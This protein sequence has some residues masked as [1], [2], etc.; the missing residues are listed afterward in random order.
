MPTS[1]APPQ[2][3]YLSIREVAT[4]LG[5]C[6]NTLRSWT[7]TGRFPAPLR[8]G[9]HLLRFDAS[10]VRAFLESQQEGPANAAV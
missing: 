9:G 8:V 4:M 1:T 10:Q 2:P 7:K 6:P 3:K 5:V